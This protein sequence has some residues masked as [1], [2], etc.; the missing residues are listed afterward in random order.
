MKFLETTIEGAYIV[1]PELIQD[2]RGFFARAWCAREFEAQGLTTRVVQ[3]NISYNRRK[4]T[5]RGMHYQ[6]APS[7]EAKLVRCSRGA[8][9]DVILDLRPDSASYKKWLSVELSADNHKMIYIPEGV[10]HGFLT[11]RDDT[12]VFYQH[13]EF[14]APGAA[15]GVRW[16]DP[17]FSIQWPISEAPIISAQDRSWPPYDS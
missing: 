4:G 6:V 10:A 14:Y 1:E 2:A 9:Y 7:Q 3:A 12:E 15:R 16:D 11:L 17:Q 13:S 5:L 8:L